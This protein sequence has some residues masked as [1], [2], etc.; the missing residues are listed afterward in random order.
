MVVTPG[1]GDLDLGALLHDQAQPSGG[2]EPVAFAAALLLASGGVVIALTLLLSDGGIVAGLFPALVGIAGGITLRGTAR[3][4]LEGI[5]HQKA[6]GVPDRRGL[7]Q[8]FV[9]SGHVVPAG[10]D[11]VELEG[12]D[13]L[14]AD[15]GGGGHGRIVIRPRP[16]GTQRLWLFMAGP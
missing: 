16:K 4:L 8:P 14:L 13:E 9:A 1:D 6:R 5:G 7:G 11:Q 2:G 3:L 10:A 15:L 12:L